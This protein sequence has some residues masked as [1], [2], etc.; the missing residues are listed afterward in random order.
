MAKPKDQITAVVRMA[1]RSAPT[2]QET[3]M[4]VRGLE[5]FVRSINRQEKQEHLTGQESSG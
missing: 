1:A 5:P 3:A 2:A 4:C